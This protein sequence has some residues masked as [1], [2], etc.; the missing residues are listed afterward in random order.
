MNENNLLI[1]KQS[2]KNN[3]KIYFVKR[4]IFKLYNQL[5]FFLFPLLLIY[6][7]ML[8]LYNKKIIP[9]SQNMFIIQFS[10]YILQFY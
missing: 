3:L 2:K 7:I 10:R 4:K 8:L 1:I 9:Y 5:S 6:I